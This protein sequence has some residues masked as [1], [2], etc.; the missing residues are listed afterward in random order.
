MSNLPFG[1]KHG[2]TGTPKVKYTAKLIACMNN[3]NSGSGN[4]VQ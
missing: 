2:Q 4:T 1:A 3:Y